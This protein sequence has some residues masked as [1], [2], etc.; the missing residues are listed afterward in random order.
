MWMW[1]I[2]TE[3]PCLDQF[4]EEAAEAIGEPTMEEYMTKTLED[5]GSRIAR[6][7]IDDKAHFELKGQLLKEQRENTFSEADNEAAN[8]HIEKVLEIVDLFHIPEV[9]QDQIMLRFFSMLLSEAASRRLRN[10]PAG[11]IPSMKV[12]D[13]KK[14]IQDMTGHSQK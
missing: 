4:E 9:T 10:E 7:K 2:V 6:P 8:E 3:L 12:V 14:A 13:A 5:Y 11:A 1:L